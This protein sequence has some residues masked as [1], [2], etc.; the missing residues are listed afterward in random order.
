MTL[1]G[2]RR[3]KRDLQE[4]AKK[5]A[6]KDPLTG[7]AIDLGEFNKTLPDIFQNEEDQAQFISYLSSKDTSRDKKY[8]KGAVDAYVD[9]R[10]WTDQQEEFLKKHVEGFNLRRA[11]MSRLHDT[12][13]VEYVRNIADTDKKI[14]FIVQKIGL[15]K[16]Y[17][18]LVAQLHKVSLEDDKRFSKI[19]K[20]M[21]DE[22]GISSGKDVEAANAKVQ[23]ALQRFGMEDGELKGYVKKSIEM[24]GGA[25]D[26]GELNVLQKVAKERM[27]TLMTIY[28]V[29]RSGAISQG[30][31]KELL[32]GV[33]AQRDLLEKSNV[34]LAD[35]G[36]A[37]HATITP[38]QRQ[39]IRRVM[40]EG[41]D[42][43]EVPETQI[44]TIADYKSVR[45]RFSDKARR[46]RFLS[47]LQTEARRLRR[48]P[49]DG[50]PDSF[51]PA[52]KDAFLDSFSASEEA[53]Q[54][55]TKGRGIWATLL[56]L[57]FKSK[58]DI[59]TKAESSWPR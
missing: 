57:I 59:R 4:D 56:A 35:I 8:S 49:K 29:M 17:A 38:E 53:L 30:R 42:L 54:N 9:G 51:T 40:I 7:E 39:E 36:K 15:E 32:S 37:L 19:V 5:S 46:D 43:Q 26:T 52:Q 6:Q 45:E 33:S 2:I 10:E 48:R 27:G 21:I 47:A 31:A 22:K 28:D 14:G 1:E 20:S 50:H 23:A 55:D 24:T 11:E 41:G 3:M 34:H 25:F 44:H 13:N 58:A 18:L 12:F 16:T